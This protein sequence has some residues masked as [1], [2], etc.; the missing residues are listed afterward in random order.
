MNICDSLK[1]VSSLKRAFGAFAITIALTITSCAAPSEVAATKNST[2]DTDQSQPMSNAEQTHAMTATQAP[3]ATEPVTTTASQVTTTAESPATSTADASEDSAEDYTR[4]TIGDVSFA[5][6]ESWNQN[7][8]NEDQRMFFFPSGMLTAVTKRKVGAIKTEA[9][10]KAYIKLFEESVTNFELKSLKEIEVMG[11]KGFQFESSAALEGM[12]MNFKET[13]F[14]IGDDFYSL[15]ASTSTGG[16]EIPK[17]YDEIIAS[18][19]VAS[20]VKEKVDPGKAQARKEQALKKAESYVQTAFM[21]KKGLRTQLDHEGY[22]KAEIDYALD[23]I[24]ADW[25]EI[26]LKSGENY[27]EFNK[28]TKSELKKQLKFEGF[29]KEEIDYALSKIFK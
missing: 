19:M 27:M 18:L 20:E 22:S 24:E 3:A 6:P 28:F 11:T 25:K 2:A 15:Q 26:A 12:P 1:K 4:Y 29:S 10:Q 5:L 13:V 16:A 21:A 9:Q 7:K 17:E 14:T 23:N 8:M